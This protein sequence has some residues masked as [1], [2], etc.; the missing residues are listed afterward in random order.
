MTNQHDQS[1]AGI[2]PDM[3]V[4]RIT[5]AVR[6]H[7]VGIWRIGLGV[8]LGMILFVLVMSLFWLVIGAAILGGLG[9]AGAA[10]RE[11]AVAL[12][13]AASPSE[14]HEAKTLTDLLRDPAKPRAPVP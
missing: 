7:R 6:D 4:Q 9:M 10:H 11:Q 1:H 8:C 3:Y 5:E 2:D 13:K 14:T 12:P